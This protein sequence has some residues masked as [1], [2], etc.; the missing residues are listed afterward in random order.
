MPFLLRAISK[1]KWYKVAW[2]EEGKAQANTLADLRTKENKLS[3]WYVNDDKSNLHQIV[4]AIAA[5]RDA[6]DKF[7]YALFDQDFLK[8]IS[9][10]IEQTAGNT[11]HKEA[12]KYW[13]R[14]TAELSAENVAG[15]ANIIMEH[16]TK[17]RIWESEVASLVKQAVTSGVI[18]VNPLKD[19]LK[20]KGFP[21][22]L[23]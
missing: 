4:S 2:L 16:G 7:D 15:I 18:D 9:V 8:K 1:P 13:H 14:D 3:F 6:P 17:E 10:G 23:E 20:R 12:D 19:R 5:G 21:N 22:W 11:F